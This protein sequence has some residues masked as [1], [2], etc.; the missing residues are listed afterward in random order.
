MCT[1]LNSASCMMLYS[2]VSEEWMPVFFPENPCHPKHLKG[3]M[4]CFHHEKSCQSVKAG[5][6]ISLLVLRCPRWRLW[7][8]LCG[9]NIVFYPVLLTLW[10]I[11][12]TKGQNMIT[13]TLC[14]TLEGYLEKYV[15]LVNTLELITAFKICEIQTVLITIR[16]KI[17]S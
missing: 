16:R 15:A 5:W 7:L 10:I 3:E 9:T 13:D 2:C 4:N 14:S 1:N 17:R 12:T 8:S 11:S 6:C